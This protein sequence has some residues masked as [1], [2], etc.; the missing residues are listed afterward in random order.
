MCENGERE[1]ERG[2]DVNRKRE[3]LEGRGGSMTLA[4]TLAQCFP[5]ALVFYGGWT[6]EQS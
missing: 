5:Y 1:R 3:K 2:R 6:T 4:S